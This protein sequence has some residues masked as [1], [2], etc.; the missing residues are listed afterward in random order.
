METAKNDL[1]SARTLFVIE[2]YKGANNRAYYSA[3]YAINAIH[4]VGGKAYKR[5]IDALANFKKDY[6]K[7]SIFPKEMVRRIGQAAEIRHASDYDDFYIVS[8][9]ESEKQLSVAGEF[10]GLAEKYCMEQLD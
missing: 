7:T 4:A 5:H 3:F 10:I 2:D 8:K 6:V 9:E 1:K